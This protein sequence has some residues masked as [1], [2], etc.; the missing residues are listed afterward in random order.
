M[1]RGAILVVSDERQVSYEFE[2]RV[3]VGAP[4]GLGDV[5]VCEK[6]VDLWAQVGEAGAASAILVA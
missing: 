2:N 5:R 1:S 6:P 4:V 3:D